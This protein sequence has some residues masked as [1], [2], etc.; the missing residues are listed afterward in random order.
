MAKEGKG[1]LAAVAQF[2]PF[3]IKSYGEIHE[4]RRGQMFFT[5]G[6]QWFNV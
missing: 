2:S 4:G 3:Y 6:L 1:Y 5:I